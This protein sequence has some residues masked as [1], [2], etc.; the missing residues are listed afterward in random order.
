VATPP[1][2][3][4]RLELAPAHEAKDYVRHP[5]I[6]DGLEAAVVAVGAEPRLPPSGAGHDTMVMGQ[7]RPAGMPCRSAR[8]T[9]PSRSPR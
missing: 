8:R 4:V 9:A 1:S 3:E 5:K 2:R 7:R 6:V